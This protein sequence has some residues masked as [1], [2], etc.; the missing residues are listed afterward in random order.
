M[1]DEV[2]FRG[3]RRFYF[4]SR[5]RKAGSEDVRA[6]FERESGQSL[7]AFF[8]AWVHGSGTPQVRVSWQRSAAGEA[9]ALLEVEQVG[10]VFPFPVT[11]TIRYANGNLEDV[12]IAVAGRTTSVRLPLKGDV[13]EITL[14]R[15]G[16]TPLIITGQ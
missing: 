16:L 4:G 7:E 6:A 12:P 9:A 8:D 14:N 10:R 1:G 5:F 11:V 3:I 15:D 13:R 2:F